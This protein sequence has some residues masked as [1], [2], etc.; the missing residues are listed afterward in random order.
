MPIIKLGAIDSTNSYMRQLCMD[1]ELED[2]TV[3]MAEHQL[4]GRG[5]RGTS[6]QSQKGKNL[7]CTVFK[8]VKGLMMEEAF[9][10]SMITSLA[11]ADA[12]K[13][14]G[15]PKVR[16]KWP[17]DILS[18]DKKVCGI[19]I[20]NIVR[21]KGLEASLIGI[22][23]N[24]NQTNFRGLPQASSLK[25]ILGKFIPVDEVM[26]QVLK[27]LKKKFRTLEGG[28]RYPV[29][30]AYENLLYRKGKPSSFKTPQGEIFPGF[31]QGID[32]NGAIKIKL[33]D[34]IIKSF[35]LKEIQLMF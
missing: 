17:N 3:V 27:Q 15:L 6:W 31:I 20:E 18:E 22:G 4:Q 35:E 23:L 30:K 34:D 24:V 12:L 10:I 8:S 1:Q 14:M 19:L 2:Y 28:Q 33:E 32:T 29:V 21:Q 25:S 11:I 5:Q 26:D 13:A 16:V 9:Q 7:T